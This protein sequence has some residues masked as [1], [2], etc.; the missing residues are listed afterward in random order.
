MN[1]IDKKTKSNELSFTVGIPTYYGGPA[2]VRAA[3]SVLASEGVENFRFIVTVDGNPLEPDIF[4]QLKELGVEVIDNQKR[5]GQTERI[6]QLI[7]LADTDILILTQDDI[8]FK[9]DALNE[10]IKSFKDNP[11]ITMV[12]AKVMPSPAETFF[13]SVIEVG[14]RLNYR[15]ATALKN[16]DNYLLSS[17]RCL[18]FRSGWAKKFDIPEEIINSDAYFYFENKRK[19]G[20]FKYAPDAIIYNKSPLRLREYLKQSKK[21]EYSKT[22][23]QKYF[24]FDLSPE[25]ALPVGAAAVAYF[26]E[27]VRRP[28]LTVSYAMIFL[29]AKMKKNTYKN[30]KRF[31]S[32]DVSTKR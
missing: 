21:F 25:Y 20:V 27:L 18:A 29:Y 28:I 19:G 24:N 14:V 16:G 30:A 7:S 23:L 17:G 2:L 12:G 9:P 13:E 32:T 8:Q 15:I 5:G 3:K 10:I 26:S 6:K 22:E 1:F 4:R 31:W 11:D